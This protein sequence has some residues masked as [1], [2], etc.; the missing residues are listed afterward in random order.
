MR[1][2]LGVLLV[3]VTRSWPG[4]SA[5]R[6]A[7]RRPSPPPAATGGTVVYHAAWG[8]GFPWFGFLF[9]PFFLFLLFGLFAFAF[10]GRRRWGG[11]PGG[12]GLGL[13]PGRVL[14]QPRRPP[15]P[16]G[17]RRPSPAPRGRG[18]GSHDPGPAHATNP[19]RRP[20]AG[21]LTSLPRDAGRVCSPGVA[22][23]VR[24]P[25]RTILVAEDE[26]QIAG[27]V[28]DY[29]EHAG[30]A[31]ITATDGAAA[32]ALARARRPDAL[33]L[34]LG[35]PRVDGLDV[36]RAIRHDS[37]VPILILSARGDEV[38]RVTGP[39]ARR[40]R[41][42]REAVQPARAG[43][44]GPGRAPPRR[45]GPPG[46]TSGSW[47]ATSSSTSSDGGCRRPAASSP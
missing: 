45:G 31:V 12:P 44:P 28:R 18:R 19:S 25:M 26:P 5:T 33:V 42:R 8:F 29:L 30:F 40:R 24:R 27:L 2:L 13:R 16:L 14:G 43:R 34:D 17:R 9:F 38:D 6:S 11:G 37:R 4:S 35:L 41:L 32:L 39:G 7:S 22:S 10:G 21:R 15:L 20:A 47:P 36:I 46:A 23:R 3:T 1:G